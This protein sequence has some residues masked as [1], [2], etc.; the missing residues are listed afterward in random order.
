MTDLFAVFEEPSRP[1][2]EPEGLKAKYHQLTAI[3]HPDV[4]GGSGD[5][6]EINRAYQILADPAA[7]I[8][9]LLELE[10]PGAISR[11]QPVPE[12]AGGGDFP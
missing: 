5:F 4:A 2:L 11:A 3:H 1:W 7:R 6:A 12:P 8:R 10:S 9:H